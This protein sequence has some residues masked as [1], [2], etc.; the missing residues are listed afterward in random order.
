MKIDRYQLEGTTETLLAQ[1]QAMKASDDSAERASA[2]WKGGCGL[3]VLVAF[4]SLWF[5][6]AVGI[7]GLTVTVAAVGFGIFAARRMIHHD[8]LDLEDRKVETLQK[9]LSLLRA[10]VPAV[11]PV[12]VDVDF[13]DYVKAGEQRAPGS[14]S[15]TW[16]RTTTAL[17]DGTALALTLA[18]D[19][20]RKERRKRKYTKIKER[21]VGEAA[22]DLR[23][24][25]QYGD[26]AAAADRLRAL[27]PP[28]GFVAAS[29]RG[30]GRRLH[31][32]LRA[33]PAGRLTARS[34]PTVTGKLPDADT[35]LVALRWAYRSLAAGA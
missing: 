11:Q 9:L 16:L 29:V 13:R 25:R 17:A 34:G 35:L 1:V 21:I 30:S 23:L 33:A 6:E 15:H 10:D 4:F 19:V 24:G 5:L 22:I 32:S 2:W 26:A 27:A 18:E 20:K 7:W 8:Q 14:W 3:S 12:K 28:P 31:A